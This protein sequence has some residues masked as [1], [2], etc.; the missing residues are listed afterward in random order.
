MARRTGG[1]MRLIV[2]MLTAILFVFCSPA[3]A[4]TDSSGALYNVVSSLEKDSCGMGSC[5]TVLTGVTCLWSNSSDSNY[6]RCS[7][8][9][10]EDNVKHVRGRKAAKL[11][12]AIQNS[13]KIED[14]CGAGTCGFRTPQDVSCRRQNKP[15]ELKVACS[16]SG[17]LDTTH[18]SS[19]PTPTARPSRGA[20]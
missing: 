5:W 15:G 16:V 18:T 14:D 7:Y 8:K 20:K 17:H 11:M 6:K 3:T 10:D 9:D 4:K 2:G 1:N 19:I 13:A 12:A